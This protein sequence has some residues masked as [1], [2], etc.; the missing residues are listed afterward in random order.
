[1]Y[2]KERKFSFSSF[3]CVMEKKR[4]LLSFNICGLVPSLFN[5]LIF[6]GHVLLLIVTRGVGS[7]G[8]ARR[9]DTLLC[10]KNQSPN[11]THITS[12][13]Q[14]IVK[15][16]MCCDFV[17]PRHFSWKKMKIM[18]VRTISSGCLISAFLEFLFVP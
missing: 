13:Q 2:E 10:L 12:Q 1:M 4:N 7:R 11:D 15:T 14:F 3:V 9:L 5:V 16:R 8:H 17:S 6:V 18:Q